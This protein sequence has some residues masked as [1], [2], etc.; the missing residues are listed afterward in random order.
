MQV[1]YPSTPAQYFHLLRRQIKRDFRRP[2]VVMT[3]KSLLRL[4]AAR[5]PVE[6]F[7]HGRFQEV[8]DDRGADPARVHRVVACSGKLFYDL[9]QRRN[10]EENREIAIVRLEQFYPFPEEMLRRTLGRYRKAREWVWAQ[11]ESQNMGGWSFVEPRLRDLGYPVE[12]VGRDA[13]ASPATGSHAIHVREQRELVEASI[14]GQAPHVVR[15]SP[16]DRSV[17]SDHA[18]TAH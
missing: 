5:S 3:P 9:Q 16:D 10:E 11:E 2:L 12:Y 6:D 14:A 7:V 18:P 17:D 15:A 4:K 8:L 1:C 13:S